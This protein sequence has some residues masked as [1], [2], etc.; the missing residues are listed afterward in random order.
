MNQNSLTPNEEKK[1]KPLPSGAYKGEI[2]NLYNDIPTDWIVDFIH[3][4]IP[5]LRPR[6]AAR[7]KKNKKLSRPEIELIVQ[8][9]DAPSGYKKSFH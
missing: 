1:L 4:D 2:Y 6:S 5:R 7:I 9:F 3:N 8:E